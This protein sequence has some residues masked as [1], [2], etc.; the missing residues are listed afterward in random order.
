MGIEKF[1]LLVVGG[2]A[3][4]MAAALTAKAHDPKAEVAILEKKEALGKKLRATGN[5]RCNLSNTAIP[6]VEETIAFFKDQGI[7]VR[8]DETGRLY[9]FSES[10][11]AVVETLALRIHQAGILV[12]TEAA[13]EAL[14]PKDG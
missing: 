9:P 13:V 14:T 6:G 8:A 1:D 5:G 4:G 7:P 2:G 3:A 10:A 12:Y 11:A